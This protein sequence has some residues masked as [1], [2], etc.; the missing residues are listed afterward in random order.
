MPRSTTATFHLIACLLAS[1]LFQLLSANSWAETKGTVLITG[2]NR[3]I[4]LAL[5]EQFIA[6]GYHVIGTA[7]SPE[8]ATALGKSGAQVEQ[9]DV[10]Q[11]ASVSAL[12]KRLGTQAIDV[13]INNAGITGHSS[14]D[15]AELDIEKLQPTFDVNTLGPLRVIQA[16]LP[17]LEQ[18]KNKLTV[19]ISSMMG[20]MEA[21]TWGCCIAYRASK[22]ALNSI[23][24]T[25]AVDLGQKGFTFVVLHPGY[26]QTDMNEGKGN[27]TAEQSASGLHK[28]I[29]K[30]EHGDN[31]KF[32]DHLGKSL[33]W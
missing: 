26:V 28:V 30:L 33:A 6:D 25:L 15:L 32:Y 4:G 10:T 22:A 2:A 24:K 14:K 3:G 7:R 29:T 5:A 31:G 9:L 8:R 13:L 21:N 23:N 11:P 17:N 16:L 27:Y 19:N 1:M 20:S 18:G 12:K